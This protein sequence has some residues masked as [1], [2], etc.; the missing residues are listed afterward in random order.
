M[1]ELEAKVRRLHREGMPVTLIA[2]T[3]GAEPAWVRREIVR[4]WRE[5]A[6]YQ[7]M[8]DAVAKAERMNAGARR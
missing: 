5:D 2:R 8:A 1:E 6:E 3:T 4:M 7:A